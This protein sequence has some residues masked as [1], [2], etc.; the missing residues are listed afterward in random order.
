MRTGV[1]AGWGCTRTT[2]RAAK[3]ACRPRR[4]QL[5][6]SGHLGRLRHLLPAPRAEEAATAAAEGRLR[7]Q[8]DHVPQQLLQ[9]SSLPLAQLSSDQRHCQLGR[10]QPLPCRCLRC[11]AACSRSMAHLRRSKAHL[12]RQGQQQLPHRVALKLQAQAARAHHL[13]S[14]STQGWAGRPSLFPTS[15]HSRQRLAATRAR[16]QGVQLLHPLPLLT[17]WATMTAHRCMSRKCT[18]KL[19]LQIIMMMET[20]L[21]LLHQPLA[22]IP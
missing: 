12:L 1:S 9:L 17:T 4:S 6:N 18:A 15:S 14:A 21:A 2:R 20:M 22:M 7:L 3:V 8:R 16:L 5:L 13:A 19:G 10:C 11:W